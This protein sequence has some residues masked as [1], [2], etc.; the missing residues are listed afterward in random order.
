M[1]DFINVGDTIEAKIIEIDVHK[2]RIILS[3]KQLQENPWDTVEIKGGEFIEVEVTRELKDGYKIQFGEI[4][5][6]LPKSN[7]SP[8][9]QV[10]VGDVIKVRVRS[11][12]PKTYRLV[13]QY[14]DERQQTREVYG[15][16]SK[17]QQQEK[18]TSSFGD[19]LGEFINKK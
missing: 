13:V 18:L 15:K 10:S 14:R 16:F 5:G 9:K 19:L 1:S 12:E 7:I 11:F 2:K 4:S 17:Q 3:R 8:N 6:Y